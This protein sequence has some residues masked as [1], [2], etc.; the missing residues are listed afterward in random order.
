MIHFL[1]K[2]PNRCGVACS[3]GVDSMAILNFLTRDKKR[4][5]SCL[6]FNHGTEHSIKTEKFV[7]EYCLKNDIPYVTSEYTGPQPTSNKEDFW[8]EIRYDFLK[9]FDYPVITCHHLNDQVETWLFTSIKHVGKLIPYQNEN[10]IR[11]F[12]ITSKSDLASWCDK[13]TVPYINDPSN[14]SMEHMRNY[15][16]H[17]LIHMVKHINPGI[18]KMIYKKILELNKNV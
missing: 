11:P 6:Y 9:S 18:D 4:D 7:R 5:V 10:I 1:G 16:R 15:I 12:L 17:E 8:R 13:H 14:E 3:G 2:L